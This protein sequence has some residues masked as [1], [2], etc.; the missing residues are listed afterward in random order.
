[1]PAGAIGHVHVD[2]MLLKAEELQGWGANDGADRAFTAPEVG[3][4]CA[5][6]RNLP[7]GQPAN[8]WGRGEGNSER[9]GWLPAEP[10]MVLLHVVIAAKAAG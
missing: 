1:M 6:A 8:D 3:H 4:S 9:A 7:K 10:Q 2:L 5:S